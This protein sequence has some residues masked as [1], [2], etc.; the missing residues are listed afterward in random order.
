MR[1]QFK[2]LFALA[3]AA[4][5]ASASTIKLGRRQEERCVDCETPLVANPGWVNGELSNGNYYQPTKSGN[6]M[7]GQTAAGSG[8]LELRYDSSTNSHYVYN[9]CPSGRNNWCVTYLAQ[10][11]TL[12]AGVDYEFEIEYQMSGV[13]SQNNLISMYLMT[14]GRST[15]FETYFYS[16]NTPAGQWSTWKSPTFRLDTAGDMILTLYW[17]NDPNNAQILIRNVKQTPTLCKDADFPLRPPRRH[18]RPF[19]LR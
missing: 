6:W 8:Q 4:S 2:T 10:V 7:L 18:L 12:Q 15:L 9:F 1:S 16:G 14:M 3:V 13:R 19:H 17:R 11:V 5:V